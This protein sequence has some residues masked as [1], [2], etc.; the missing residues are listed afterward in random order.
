M[1]TLSRSQT[2]PGSMS[3]ALR[4]GRRGQAEQPDAADFEPGEGEPLDELGQRDIGQVHVVGEPL[5]R[6]FHAHSPASEF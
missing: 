4:P 2:G 1:T 3:L 6:D 5:E